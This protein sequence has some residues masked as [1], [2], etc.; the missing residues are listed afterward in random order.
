MRTTT[1]FRGVWRKGKAYQN[2]G[3][4]TSIAEK[5]ENEEQEQRCPDEEKTL[6]EDPNGDGG[7]LG[8]EM[9]VQDGDSDAGHG[10]VGQYY[11]V[12]Y[13]ALENVWRF[14]AKQAQ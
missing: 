10:L 9:T 11:T 12:L 8:P 2:A 6:A 3:Q 13:N 1:I 14:Y 4:F 5:P 7:D